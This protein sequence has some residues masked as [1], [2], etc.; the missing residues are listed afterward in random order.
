MK[1]NCKPG[2]L[3]FVTQDGDVIPRGAIVEVLNWC[4]PAF[5][6]HSGRWFSTIWDVRWRGRTHSLDGLQF[7]IPDEFL[8]PLRPSDDPDETLTWAGLPADQRLGVP[9]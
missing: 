1:L 3:A 8:R 7:G 2:D 5:D 9:A 6:I 4:G